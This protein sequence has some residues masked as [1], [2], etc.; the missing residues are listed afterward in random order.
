MVFIL[1]GNGTHA[2]ANAIH[3]EVYIIKILFWLKCVFNVEILA[4]YRQGCI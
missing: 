4:R 3:N 1:G 2:G